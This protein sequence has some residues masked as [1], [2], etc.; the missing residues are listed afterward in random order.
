MTR[1]ILTPR[2]ILGIAVL[3]APALLLIAGCVSRPERGHAPPA[4]VP[5]MGASGP[6]V[7][8]S[9]FV[10]SSAC[11]SCHPAE[12]RMHSGSHHAMSLHLAERPELGSQMPP[13]GRVP[14]TDI[15]LAEKHGV[16]QM[17]LAG[18][19]GDALPLDAAFG[20]G[21]TG[22][23]YVAFIGVEAMELHKSYFPRLRLWYLTPGHE[24]Q[25]PSDVGMLHNRTVTRECV[26]CHAV[27][28]PDNGVKPERR[29]F[30]VGCE[31]CHGAGGAHAAAMKAGNGSDL[32]IERLG[33]LDATHLNNLC[34]RCHRG[35]QSLNMQSNQAVMTNRFQPYGLMKS[36]CFVESG[37]RLSCLTCHNPHTNAATDPRT[38]ERV[39]LTCHSGAN[40][41]PAAISAEP[42]HACPI[43][44]NKGCIGCHMPKRPAFVTNDVPTRMA[45]HYIHV[46]RNQ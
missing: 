42:V 46:V 18:Q 44:R 12:F 37:N 9:T 27:T 34:A 19:P 11:Q 2:A 5:S 23:T 28:S 4:P 35:F 45:D 25:K 41:A 10:G 43:D 22:M 7:N 6:Q 14:G 29:F 36:R 17:T 13:L 31:S 8:E 20:S 16:L 33:R 24:K 15:V 26:L 21:K 39:C 32:K 1:R 40:K 30:G 38:Y 3:A